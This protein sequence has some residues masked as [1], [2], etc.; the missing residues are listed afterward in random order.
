MRCPPIV[1]SCG[2]S[3]GTR[4]R[5]ATI[6]TGAEPSIHRPPP[7]GRISSRVARVELVLDLADELLED[8]L[9]RDQ[10]DDRAVL[11]EHER[12]VPAVAAHLAQHLVEPRGLGDAARSA[13]RAR[14]GRPQPRRTRPRSRS[15]ALTKPTAASSPPSGS[16]SGSRVWPVSHGDARPPHA[17]SGPSSRSRSP[18]AA[19]SPRGRAGRRTPAPPPRAAAPRRSISPPSR[20]SRSS[21]A[22]LVLAVRRMAGLRCRRDAERLEHEV[23]QPVED[24]DERLGHQVER[25][26][27]RRQ[28]ERDRH[29]PRDRRALRAPA[30]RRRRGAR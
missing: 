3:S 7:S 22:Q 19:S 1:A 4:S 29:R 23:A 21:V 6:R 20:L 30:R 9:E 5:S 15:F 10:P 2:A 11:V 17:A 12:H 13:A 27:R 18:S 24:V 25:P 26:H 16:H 14:A 8:V 28:R